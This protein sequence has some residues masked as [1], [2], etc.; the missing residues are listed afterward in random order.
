MT[1]PDGREPEIRD[2]AEDAASAEPNRAASKADKRPP[3][4]SSLI[5]LAKILAIAAVI[6]A[7]WAGV[8]SFI[9]LL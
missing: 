7:L 8:G 1:D 9:W 4:I 5:A 6:Y 3:P 2:A